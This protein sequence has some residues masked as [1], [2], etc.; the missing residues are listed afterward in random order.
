[1]RLERDRLPGRPS[2]LRR[3]GRDRSEVDV[4]NLRS[5]AVYSALAVTATQAVTASLALRDGR[6]DYADAVWGPGLAAVAAVGAVAGRG[7][8]PRRWGLATGTAVWAAR[9]A[10]AMLGRIRGSDEEDPRYTEFL[11]GDS[12]ADVVVKVFVTQGL[13]QLFVSAPVQ[14]P[15][16]AGCPAAGAAGWRPRDWRS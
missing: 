3:T 6:R 1:M 13:A 16:P 8:G 4:A 15:R 10:H 7:D 12:T 5:V 14:L 11:E 2:A 9:L